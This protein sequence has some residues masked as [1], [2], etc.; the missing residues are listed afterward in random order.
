LRL[1]GHATLLF[2]VGAVS[3]YAILS[4][5]S[6]VAIVGAMGMDGQ[7]YAVSDYRRKLRGAS[8]AG[9]KVVIVPAESADAD[10]HL[11]ERVLDA[12]TGE[13]KLERVKLE[14]SV[15]ESVTVV[16]AETFP[17]ILDLCASPNPTPGP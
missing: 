11:V 17:D 10:G 14:R 1:R 7:L 15:R 4:T 8:S 13:A 9:V 6:D 16:A 12:E 5:R 2:A 3:T